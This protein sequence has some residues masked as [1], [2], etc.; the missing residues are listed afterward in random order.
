MHLQVTKMVAPLRTVGDLERVGTF[1]KG[2]ES[3]TTNGKIWQDM[4]G[5]TVALDFGNI[6]NID[7]IIGCSSDQCPPCPAHSRASQNS[8]FLARENTKSSLPK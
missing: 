6:G 8:V 2:F 4:A 5:G 3:P 1:R 7:H